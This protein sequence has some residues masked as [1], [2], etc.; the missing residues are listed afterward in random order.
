MV[1]NRFRLSTRITKN[2]FKGMENLFHLLFFFNTYI[3]QPTKM[4]KLIL[5]MKSIYLTLLMLSLLAASCD[6][7]L[8]K[9]EVKKEIE[10]NI[11]FNYSTHGVFYNKSNATEYIYFADYTSKKCLKIFSLDGELVDSISL[12]S[13]V[14]ELDE[15][16]RISIISP[17]TIVINSRY[18]NKIA[19]LNKK[20]ICW[21]RLDLDTLLN[22][23][24]GNHYEIGCS[25][26]NILKDGSLLFRSYFK[27]NT[28]D[29]LNKT[30]PEDQLGYMKYFYKNCYTS[31]RLIKVTNIYSERPTV[32]F[33]LHNFYKNI[34]PSPDIITESP[35]YSVL[36]NFVF[37]F[38]VFSDQLFQIN[39]KTLT[40]EKKIQIKSK[41]SPIGFKPIPIN[42]QTILTVQ[43][44]INQN[45]RTKGFLSNIFYNS[46]KNEYY[47]LVF[48]E[49]KKENV[50]KQD[51]YKAFSVIIYDSTFTNSREYQFAATEYQSGF[52]IMTEE[53]LMIPKKENTSDKIK[54]GK[55]VFVLFSFD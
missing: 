44:V 43:D 15:I 47:V 51:Y 36:N 2:E 7:T 19:I 39:S 32:T 54:N 24:N 45:Y 34:S 40:I 16:N 1:Y 31:P 14:E 28:H 4:L 37:D 35:N 9:A 55:T 10:F 5:Q 33:A 8:N 30:E 48:H 42:E 29:L 27:Y 49:I 52:A 11:G 20:G 38:S 25:I 3:S 26:P 46:T 18:S 23:K 41:Y 53:G 17:D 50:N 22:D 12:K 21:K 13:A 6:K